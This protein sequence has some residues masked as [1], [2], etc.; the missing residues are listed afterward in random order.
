MLRKIDISQ[1]C[2]GMYCSSWVELDSKPNKDFL[3]ADELILDQ[4]IKSANQEIFIDTNKGDDVKDIEP[5]PPLANEI[6]SP[7]IKEVRTNHLP[8]TFNVELKEASQ[9]VDRSKVVIDSMFN[10]ARMGKAINID[11]TLSIVEEITAS[12]MRNPDALISI[13]RLK[14]KDNYTYMHSVAVCALMVSLAKE[15][16][17][18][19]EQIRDAGLAG[20]LHDIGKMTIPSEIL[21]NPGKLTAAEFEQVKNHPKAGYEILLECLGIC[22]VALDVCLHH[23]EKMDGTGYPYGLSGEEISVFARMG[24]VCD[25]YD[26]ITSNRSYKQGWCPSESLR[27]MASWK[28]HLD[29]TIFH[30]FIKCIGIYPV[31]TLVRLKS[32]GI[33]VVMEQAAGKSLL[34]PKVKV[35]YNSQSRSYFKPQVI[36][37]ADN[38]LSDSIVS[39]E[40]AENLRLVDIDQYWLGKTPVS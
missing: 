7:L 26:A 1:V 33:G 4:I 5:L 24:A 9:I 16:E 39:R 37:L 27:Q 18:S 35:F 32:G 28:G 34:L 36:D 11:D 10:E 15:L 22:A 12:V 29:P 3:I 13:A 17:F 6:I 25:V 38:G 40:N 23:H 2:I 30:A 31:G 8:T 21:N 19:E 20:L 14:T